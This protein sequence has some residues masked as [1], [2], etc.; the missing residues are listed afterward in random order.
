M[1][2]VARV[3]VALQVLGTLRL[4]YLIRVVLFPELVI[5][6]LT[7]AFCDDLLMFTFT[8]VLAS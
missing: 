5:I 7:L 2:V 8:K 1:A 3:S 4:A 6:T